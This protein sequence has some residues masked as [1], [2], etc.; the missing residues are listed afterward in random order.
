MIVTNISDVSPNTG[1]CNIFIDNEFSFSLIPSDIEYFK[2]KVGEEIS[3]E[4][5]KYITDTIIYI[6][7]QNTAL[8]YL[9]Y[10]MRS[11]YEVRQ[12]LQEKEF[13]EQI[14]ERVIEFLIKYKYV[15]DRKYCTA[16]IK[17]T[18]K[19]KPKGKYAIRLELSQK[20]INKNIID[21]VL[22]ESEIDEAEIIKGIIERKF[23]G[24]ISEDSKE[25]KRIY[26]FLLRKGFGYD[27][28]KNVFN[29][30]KRNQ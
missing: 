21:E 20:G 26:N 12:K 18:L 23:K 11:E 27:I 28:I 2:L 10:K 6:K 24:I 13:T 22:C 19:L 8:K 16:F 15:D 4:K 5:Y 30:I 17:E 7:A 29:E 9:G 3:L 14:I 1:R 25:K